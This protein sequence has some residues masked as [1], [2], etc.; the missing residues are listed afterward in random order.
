MR[1]KVNVYEEIVAEIR[2]MIAVGALQPGE[3]LPSVRQYAVERKVNP[4]TVAKA[5]TALEE[6]G[7]LCVQLKKGAYVRGEERKNIGKKSTVEKQ[8][9]E[10]QAMG[11][12]KEEILAAA[13]NVYGEK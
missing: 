13:A 10:W 9:K 5:Y 12:T 2:K 6:E 11:V 8:M 4:N 1:G 3:K 7:L